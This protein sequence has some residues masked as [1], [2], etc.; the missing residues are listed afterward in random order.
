[1]SPRRRR[2]SKV[3]IYPEAAV[4]EKKATL[5]STLAC[6]MFFQGKEPAPLTPP[7]V[8]LTLLG[9]SIIP[10]LLSNTWLLFFLVIIC[11]NTIS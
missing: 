9:Y 6:Q 4:Q 3:I 7:F 10:S 2:L 5:G 1:M 11:Y 8:S